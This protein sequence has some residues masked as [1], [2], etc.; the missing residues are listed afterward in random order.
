MAEFYSNSSWQV[1]FRRNL[2]DWEIVDFCQLLLQL[3][4]TH[5]D[6]NKVDSLVWKESKDRKFTVRNCYSLLMK[7]AGHSDTSWPW[8]VIS[9]TKAPINAACL[10]WIAAREACLTQSN[11]QKRVLH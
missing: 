6:Q 3:E 10:G 2:N 4:S 1:S 8:K 5:I 11:L 9:K 7:Q